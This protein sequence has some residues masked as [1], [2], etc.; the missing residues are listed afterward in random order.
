MPLNS[1]K[2]EVNDQHTRFGAIGQKRNIENGLVESKYVIF[3]KR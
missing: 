3:L 2:S 1:W